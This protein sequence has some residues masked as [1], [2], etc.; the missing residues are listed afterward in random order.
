MATVIEI[1]DL[2]ITS[3]SIKPEDCADGKV[4]LLNECILQAADEIR[5]RLAEA[6]SAEQLKRDALDRLKGAE[7]KMHEYAASCEVGEERE[8]AFE[9]YERIRVATRF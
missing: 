3:I 2:G 6:V 8:K 7:R 4:T 1:S 9:V 5:S